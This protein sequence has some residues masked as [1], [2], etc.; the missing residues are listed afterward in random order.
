MNNSE[1]LDS[2][3]AESTGNEEICAE[4]DEDVFDQELQALE[5]ANN[6]EDEDVDE[7]IGTAAEDIGNNKVRTENNKNSSGS[8]MV[9]VA[10]TL[11]LASSWLN[12]TR[13]KRSENTP[14]VDS[15][16]EKLEMAGPSHL[17]RNSRKMMDSSASSIV[18]DPSGSLHYWWL[19][20]ISIS[21]LYNW[22]FII[23]RIAFSDLQTN[24]ISLWLT[25]DYLS[26]LIYIVDMIVQFKI[27]FMEQGLLVRDPKQLHRNY[28]RKIIFKLDCLSIIPLDLFYFEVGINSVALRLNRLLRLHRMLE[29]RATI[30]TISRFPNFLRLCSLIAM[31][32]LIFHWNACFY[33]LLSKWI[34]FGSDSWV[35]PDL[36]SPGFDSLTRQYLFSLY[37]SSRMLTTGETENPP[38]TDVELFFVTVD[39]TV[40]FLVFAAIVGQFGSMIT[41]MLHVRREFLEQAD[42]VKQYLVFHEIDADLQR[43]VVSWFNYMWGTKKSSLD[44]D[45]VLSKLPHP[46]KTEIAVQVHLETL[47]RVQVFA[48]VEPGL[49]KEIVLKLRSQVYSPGDFICKKGEPGKEMYVVS[50]GRL[51]VVQDD[52]ETVIATLNE[53]SY[54]GEI[55]IL[56]LS[57]T[58]NRRTANVRSEGYSELLCL[59]KEDLLEALTEYPEARKLLEVRGRRL[60]RRS[61]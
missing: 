35:Y 16:L 36:T 27:G 59:S 60:L 48:D 23:A 1:F 44:R 13:V 20:V 47:K 9:Q 11:Q 42:A 55:S 54:F 43:R 32:L 18:I 5:N 58:G 4:K 29:L 24:T 31:V 7:V 49:L 26:D 14:R 28:M 30:E 15:F 37:W 50:S 6:K 53:G 40:G 12:K 33:F 21:V 51:Q 46:L 38:Q 57:N 2:V 19:I 25:F 34:G 61:R 17:T 45:N 10:K 39:L 56:N 41:H 52:Q 8:R 22:I 3:A